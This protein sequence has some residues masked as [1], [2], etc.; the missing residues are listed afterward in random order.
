M[1]LALLVALLG[2]TPISLEVDL[3]RPT[4]DRVGK[5]LETTMQQRLA[6]DGF[7]LS[8]GAKLKL[9]VEELHGH[10]RLSARVGDELIERDFTPTGSE[11]RE[12]LTFELSQ[13]V[14]MLAHE[15]EPLA[16]ELEAKLA[17]RKALTM[18]AS[19]PGEPQPAPPT[20]D[21]LPLKPPPRDDTWR[22]GAGVRAGVSFRFPD[23]DFALGFHGAMSGLAVQ[24]TAYFG[25][26]YSPGAGFS[27]IDVPLT[28]GLRAPVAIGERF[29]LTPELLV[30]P[31]LHLAWGDT[32]LAEAVRFAVDAFGSLGLMFAMQLGQLR[33]GLRLAGELSVARTHEVNAVTV[34]SRPPFGLSLQLVLERS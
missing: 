30:G 8:K 29:S 21:P 25:G 26:V 23:V 15:A 16:L 28:I 31:K 12:E 4:L 34:W 10:F 17:E 19:Q 7:P 18:E 33:L 6:E 9:H 11:W 24:P 27:V 32:A 3:S 13:R 5:R 2:V 22:V 20:E 1:H 14:V